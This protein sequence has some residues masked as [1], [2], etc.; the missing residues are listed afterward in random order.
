MHGVSIR[1]EPGRRVALV[2][3]TG[4]GKSTVAGIAAGALTPQR[5]VVRVGGVD[6][7]SLTPEQRRRHIA[8]VSQ[9]VHVFAG[10]LV[11][12]LRLA[13]ADA[14]EDQVHDALRAVGADEWVAALEDGLDTV[15]GEGGHELTSAQ[16]Q[17]LALARL[18]LADPT[19]AILDEAT[20]EAG[21]QGARELERAA[22]AVTA[23]RTTLIIAHRLTQAASADR[24]IVMAHGRVVEEGSHH[25]LVAAGGRYAQLWRAWAADHS[26]GEYRNMTTTEIDDGLTPS[27][28]LDLLREWNN[29]SWPDTTTTVPDAFARQVELTPD[30][31]AVVAGDVRLTYRELADRSYQLANHLR[32]MGVSHEQMVAIALPRSVEMVVAAMAILAAGG[33]F[34]PVDPQWPAERRRQVIADTRATSVVVAPGT[35]MPDDPESVEIDLD[36]G[37]SATSPPPR[38]RPSSTAA[39]WP[40]SSS[41]PGRPASPRAR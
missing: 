22:A 5:G 34:V 12:D 4:A 15:V 6:V 37:R 19:V 21:S 7:A 39:S 20:A 31:L 2:G 36:A 35:A 30:A 26:R 27:D 33:A 16:A 40:T 25:D 3:S 18:M 23:G 8:I 1:L 9:E 11:D 28:R 32:A 14:T 29:Q 10:A 17:Q 38:R 13:K 24:V 41:P